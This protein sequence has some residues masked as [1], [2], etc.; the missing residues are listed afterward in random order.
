MSDETKQSSESGEAPLHGLL[1]EY[2]TPAQLMAASEKVRDG[3]YRDW[4]TFTP[5]PVHGIESAMGVKSTILP[6]LVLGGGLTGCTVAVGFQWWAN[7]VDYPFLISG[8]PFWSLP[9]NIPITF[10]LT[11][12]FAS[13]TAVFGMLALN[14]LP[15]P[16]HPLDL[17]E[18]FARSTD[19]RF[20]VLVQASDPAFDE[21]E[22]RALLEGTGAVAVEA[23]PEDVKSEA[24]LP[25]GIVYVLLILA[26]FSTIPF[27][28]AAYAREAKSP[29]PRHHIVPDMDFQQKFKAQRENTFFADHEA[30]RP[31]V[32]GTVAVGE[33]HDDTHLYQGKEGGAY[34]RTFPP[35]IAI[36]E[37][38]MQHGKERFGIYC[39]PCHGQVGEGDG[40][41]NARATSLAEGTWVPPSNLTEDR[42]RVMPVGEIFNT[43]TNGVRNMPGYGRQIPAE[44][45]WA[46]ILYVR[47]LQ[48]SRGASV[49]DLSGEERASLK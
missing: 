49:Q 33:L 22:T 42:L 27:A 3:G 21:K 40:M 48:R 8:K 23:V 4:D 9:A 25:R 7:G 46:I 19:D 30:D 17:K 24:E 36:E 45:R 18:R 29:L 31:Q 15:L 26:A 37:A 34:A 16:A 13:L 41:V 10:E 5:F 28:L 32:E 47:A 44:D 6:W 39:T 11:V 1:A 12:L 20:Y 14:K 38:T 43:I 2:E 35:S